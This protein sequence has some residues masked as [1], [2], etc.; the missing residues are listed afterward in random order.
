MNMDVEQL[1][2][3]CRTG[4]QAAWGRLVD[5]FAG[6]VF[7]IARR[8]ALREDQ[9]ED[10]AQTVFSTL[11]R[12][13]DQIEQA[14]A[15]Q[16]WLATTTKRECWRVIK[17]A[18]RAGHATGSSVTEPSVE[19]AVDE[20]LVR[21][22]AAQLVRLALEQIGHKC[23][24]LI[25]ELFLRASTP[26]YSAIA[27]RLSI[28]IGSIGPTRNRCLAKLAERLRQGDVRGDKAISP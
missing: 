18:R 1:I 16:G 27:A 20:L 13:I 26:D 15:L 23:R 10:V 22:E 24:L 28:P 7:A 4:D 12:R 14:A 5:S 6:Y 25:E 9:C 21:V 11:S 8:H 3:R 2:E 19:S 17:S